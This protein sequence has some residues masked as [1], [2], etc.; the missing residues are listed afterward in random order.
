MAPVDPIL[1]T[2]P[3]AGIAGPHQN[4]VTTILRAVELGL[5]TAAQ[6]ELLIGRVRAHLN[7][8]PVV[9]P[10]S[11]QD[12]VPATVSGHASDNPNSADRTVL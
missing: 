10:S 6:A 8:L 4:T 3:V 11:V 9:L 5:F 12:G 1:S 7:A 2:G